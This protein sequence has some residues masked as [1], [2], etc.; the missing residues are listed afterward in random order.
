MSSR[1]ILEDLQ[2]PDGAF[3]LATSAMQLLQE[4]Y[5]ICRSITGDGVRRTIDLLGQHASITRFEVPSGTPVFDWEV[6]LEWNVRQAYISNTAGERLV[7][8]ERHALHLLSYSVPVRAR[9]PLAELRPHLY[10]LPDHPDWIPYRTSYWRKEW[11]FCLTQRQLDALPEGQYDVVIDTSLVPGSLTYAECKIQGELD[12]EFL[13][14]THICHPAL[15]NDNAS[16]LA[17]AT[18]LAAELSSA[19]P[20]LSYRFVFAPATIGSI[21]WLACNVEAARALRGG[22]VVGLLGDSGPLTYK[23]SRQGNAE[24]D[25]IAASAVRALDRSARVVEFSPYGY[26]ER[27]FCS[28]GFDLPVGR[29]T[30]SPNGEYPEYHTSADNPDLMSVDALANSVQALAHIIDRVDSNRRLRRCDANC[31]P[32]LGKHGLFRSTG[33]SAP[34]EFEYALL[35]LLNQADGTHGP[36]DIAAAAG[37][38]DSIVADGVDALLAAGLVDEVDRP[39]TPGT[40]LS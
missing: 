14:F 25:F 16:G 34:Q 17:I 33:G 23:R 37:L 20:R 29:L 39:W 10:S 9:M 36:H 30:R 31:E 11:G 12:D 13:I 22:L 38:P 15:A 35:W 19:K 4:I 28:P 21:T 40:G 24:I 8:F 27:Q 18:L 1:K 2:Q 7:D 6:P 26:D 3:R 32:R 5:P